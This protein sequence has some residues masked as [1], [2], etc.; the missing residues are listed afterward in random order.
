MMRGI[1]NMLDDI[2]VGDA[3]TN[4]RKSSA[5]LRD[6]LDAMVRRAHSSIRNG[7]AGTVKDDIGVLCS[8]VIR[9]FWRASIRI[10]RGVY[11]L[12]AAGVGYLREAG[13]MGA[14]R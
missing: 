3:L 14:L 1:D 6:G 9:S 10:G 2:R 7:D 12:A 8:S 5:A 4:E 11:K 13:F